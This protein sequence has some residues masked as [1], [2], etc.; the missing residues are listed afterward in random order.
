MSAAFRRIVQL[1]LITLVINAGGWT[2]NREAVADAFLEAP[3]TV[4][5]DDAATA[6]QPGDGKTGVKGVACNHWCHAVDHFV[7]IF[8]LHPPLLTET[9][10]D[11]FAGK[12]SIVP[13]ALPEGHYRPPRLFS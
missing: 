8:S 5:A 6:A 1:L 2:F 9:P 13:P 11:Y 12:R 4:Q 3:Q 7:G 10:G